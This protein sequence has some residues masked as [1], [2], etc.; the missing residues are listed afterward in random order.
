MKKTCLC[1]L[2]IA[3]L[4]AMVLAGPSLDTLLQQRLGDAPLAADAVARDGF[5]VWVGDH[6][7]PAMP[8]LQ[9]GDAPSGVHAEWTWRDEPEGL[10]LRLGATLQHPDR[11]SLL[12][13]ATLEGSELSAPLGAG[14]VYL[15]QQR[16]QWGPGWM[17][18]L[19]LDGNAPPIAAIGWHKTD[20]RRPE[21]SWLRWLGPWQADMFM[22]SLGGHAQPRRPWLIGMRLA[23]EPLEGWTLGLSRT[24]EWGGRGRDQSLRSLWRALSGNDN[25][26]ENGI[27]EHNQPG[28]QMA[29]FDLRY[30]HA[31][32]DKGAV[33][34]SAYAQAVG[35][36]EAGG[37]PSKMLV[38]AGADVGGRLSSA[39]GS[40]G[41]GRWRAFVEWAD[42]GMRHGT[43]G[44]FQ[45]GAYRHSAFAR[46]YSQYGVNLGHPIGGD[47]TLLSVGGLL[48]SGAA[49]VVAVLHR[50]R[51]LEG[52]QYFVP[53]ER[54]WG[55]SL[56]LQAPEAAAWR[57]G[58]AFNALRHSGR[59]EVSSQ[60]WLGRA[61]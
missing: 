6:G 22:G 33:D 10:R 42:T 21:T 13:V 19:I 44:E 35:E 15:S 31:A 29:G 39:E 14:R 50:G 51:A 52:S 43:G 59:N 4:P 49:Q 40:G 18:S 28:N 2:L 55:A 53:G 57:W 36:D 37:L 32:R 7:M 58:A 34:W 16:R 26:G 27:D 11:D 56:A 12:P 46:G 24:I 54:L 60:A 38:L 30:H 20:Q 8:R 17:G 3:A 25:V 48:G 23:V 61:W 5:S 9:A 41:A 45:P 47:A 1:A